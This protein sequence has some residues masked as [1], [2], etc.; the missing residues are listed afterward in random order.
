MYQA[1]PQGSEGML[2]PSGCALRVK[3]DSGGLETLQSHTRGSHSPPHGPGEAV[4][5]R[6]SSHSPHGPGKLYPPR[7]FD[8]GSR[9]PI[10]L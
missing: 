6:G 4:S 3:L 9:G 5:P 1:R 7:G 2:E 10:D 8:H